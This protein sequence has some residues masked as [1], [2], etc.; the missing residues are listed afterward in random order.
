MQSEIMAVISSIHGFSDPHALKTRKIGSNIAVE[1]HLRFNP[2]MSVKEAHDIA[3]E[4]ENK[5]KEKYGAGTHV[6]T[7][8]ET[9][10]G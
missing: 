8:I 5:L 9:V 1:V 2:S 10:K 3:T 7:H 4:V 6:I